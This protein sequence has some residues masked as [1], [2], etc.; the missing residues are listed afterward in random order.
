MTFWF[1]AN[2]QT[3][4]TVVMERDE[5]TPRNEPEILP[6]ATPSRGLLCIPGQMDCDGRDGI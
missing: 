4:A 5:I 1:F 6:I 2:R 3:A